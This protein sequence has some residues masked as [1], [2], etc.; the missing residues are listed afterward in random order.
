MF[1]L[2]RLLIIVLLISICFSQGPTNG[3]GIGSLQQWSSASAG[4]NSSLG[5][6]PSYRSHISLS[7]PTT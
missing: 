6:I 5:M 3:Y 2:D 1:L 7:N 4:G